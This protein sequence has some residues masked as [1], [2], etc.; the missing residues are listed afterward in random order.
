MESS[1]DKEHTLNDFLDQGEQHK[2]NNLSGS[3]S[4]TP[5]L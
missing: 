1:K 5:N 3:G 4:S 2:Q